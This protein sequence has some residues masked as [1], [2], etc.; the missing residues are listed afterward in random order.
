MKRNRISL[1]IPH[2]AKATRGKHKKEIISDILKVMPRIRFIGALAISIALIGG[3]M[4]FRFVRIAPYTA[5][6]ISVSEVEPLSS[7]DSLLLT[8]F[9]STETTLST[10][11]TTTLS[12][13]DLI[14]RQLFTDYM[15][16]KS[17]GE[18]TPDD[19]KALAGKYAESIKNSDV[20]IP[21]ANINQI[22]VLS[23]SE[24]NLAAYGNAITN[25]RNKYKNL[26]TTEAQNSGGDITDT[27][28]QAFSTFMGAVGKLYKSAADELL[29]VRVPTSLAQNHVDLINNYLESAEVMTSISGTAKDPIRA[30]ATLSIYA[31]HSEKESE[32]LL[33]IQ[34]TLMANGIIFD[35]SI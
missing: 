15:A 10:T 18:L 3:A 20:S 13:T 9:F 11:S 25:I 6:V 22:I 33:N 5:Q 27:S 8:D 32:L 7:E 21:K 34:K 17:Q 1:I 4:W 16:L 29:L 12:Q 19:I 2:F 30:Y 35:S 24:V 28:S 14:G 31:Q 26:V 23:D